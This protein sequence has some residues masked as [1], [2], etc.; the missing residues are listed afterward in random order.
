M[1]L[2]LLGVGQAGGKVTEAFLEYADR[3]DSGIIVDALAINTA[4]ADLLGLD[5]IQVEKRLLFGTNRV[6]DH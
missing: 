6:K 3:T 1:R 5:R 2:A 4:K